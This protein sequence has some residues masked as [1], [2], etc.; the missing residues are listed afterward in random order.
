[1]KRSL[2]FMV[3]FIFCLITPG[4]IMAHGD[5]GTKKGVFTKHFNESLF[6]ITEKGLFSVEILYDDKEYKIGK[7]L[8]GIVI[9]DEEDKDVEGATV[10][11]TVEDLSDI[12][13]SLKEIEI[14]QD[15]NDKKDV[16]PTIK[17]TVDGIPISPIRVKEK[18]DGLYTVSGLNIHRG[19]DW[20]LIIDVRVKKKQDRAIFDF[21]EVLLQ[22]IPAGK[23]EFKHAHHPHRHEEY[24]KL[25]N[26]ITYN[27]ESI[28]KGR[29][30]FKKHCISCH[31]LEKKGD[32]FDLQDN[33]WI[34][35]DTD[36]EIFNVIS[37][38]VPG[39]AMRG[40]KGELSAESIWHIV[41]YLKSLRPIKQ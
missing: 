30:I 23:Y 27:E 2:I 28:A 9:H 7:G 38:G 19:S 31:S 25:K 8:V 10:K 26:P 41:N 1:M 37:D 11:I 17:I 18:G 22:K 14:I 4:I 3:M 13:L 39:T 33:L 40:F 34:H 12:S 36:G 6:K 20:R 5:H 15:K 29:D 24:A 35:G 21:P 32:I 16:K